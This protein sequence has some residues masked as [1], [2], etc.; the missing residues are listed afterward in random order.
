MWGSHTDDEYS[1]SDNNQVVL[2]V[3]YLRQMCGD[4]LVSSDDI[5]ET[6]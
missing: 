5:V 6:H 1:R 4:T 3:I 2:H